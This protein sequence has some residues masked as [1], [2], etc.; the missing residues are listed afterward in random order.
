V[1]NGRISKYKGILANA[2]NIE[3]LL[4]GSESGGLSSIYE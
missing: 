2:P 4:Y 1:K 3:S